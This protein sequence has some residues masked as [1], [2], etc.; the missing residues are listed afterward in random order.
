VIVASEDGQT[1]PRELWIPGLEQ[2]LAPLPIVTSEEVGLDRSLAN[3]NLK[4]FAPRVGL[5]LD[6]FGN[7]KTVMRAGYGIY[8]NAAALNSVS[9]QSQS[10]PFFK[11]IAPINSA[12]A[13][14]PI[15]TILGNPLLGLPAFQSYDINF[16]PPYFQ[17]WNFGLQQLL[18][19]NLL[20][21][22]QYL[23][24]KGTHLFT[25]VWYNMPDPSPS[26]TPPPSTRAPFPNLA[27]FALQ[28][29]AASS[30]YHALVLRTEKRLSAGLMVMASYTFS[31]SIDND[32]LGN[33][34]VSSNLDQSNNKSL[35]RG[36]SSFD[37][38]HR[39]VAS[40]TYDLPFKSGN[41][42]LFA[43]FG[44]WQTGGIITQQS[45]QPFTVNIN[46][47]R[48]NVGLNNQRPNLVGNPNLPGDQ[49]TPERWFNTSAFA[50][51]PTGTFGTAGRNIVTG[52]G[53]NLVDFSLL[54]NIR[55]NERHRLQFRT[56]FFNLFNHPNFDFPERICTVTTTP[57]GPACTG[58]GSISA[59]R[60][61][62]ILQF[63]LK[64]LF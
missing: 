60:D 6:M 11:R 54:K 4:N 15:E 55:I 63:G 46:T 22:A 58:F 1:Y 32:S 61:P 14:A 62:R 27:N 37:A 42:V 26:S 8:Y 25:N 40:F 49:R 59:A 38:R 56:E 50:V 52:P 64:Y 10:P 33:S 21:E 9:T 43:L 7:Q 16:L 18:T 5:A 2:Q 20:V 23:G 57:T 12:T 19:P 31:K 30:N 17:Q 29:G 53:T 45:G 24:S 51:Q 47:D 41:K 35:E 39:F 44:N 13:P 48:A 34:V 28:T 3:K 36:L